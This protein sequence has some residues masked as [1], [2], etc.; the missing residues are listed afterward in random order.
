MPLRPAAAFASL[1]IAMLA[2]LPAAAEQLWMPAAPPVP[3]AEV[4]LADRAAIAATWSPARLA[5]ADRDR[6][7]DPF[8]A[9]GSVLGPRF[10]P[11]FL[12]ATTQLLADALYAASVAVVEAKEHFVRLRP[13]AVDPASARCP[14]AELLEP[15]R[16]WPSGHAAIGH[17]WAVLLAELLPA[18]SS[19]LL[20]RGHDYG[21]SRVVCGFHWP[22]DVAEGQVLG[23]IVADRI[24]ADPFFAPLL[25]AA[26]IELGPFTGGR[27][28]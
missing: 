20:A 2:A 8:A 23:T 7:L 10:A 15:D 21:M 19:A 4:D 26:Q 5:L 24:L 9:F 16:S 13:F 3:G 14:G 22:S 25:D 17:V 18:E 1:A 27:R 12:P 28:G 6:I 11:A